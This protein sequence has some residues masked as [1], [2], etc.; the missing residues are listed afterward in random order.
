MAEVAAFAEVRLWGRT[1]GG[2]AE[3]DDGAVVF[4]YDPAFRR[5]GL[6]ISPTHLPLSTR[7]PVRF[8]ELTR[9]PGFRGLP[10]VLAD[11]LP[12]A[13]GTMV[14]RAYYTARGEVDKAFSPVQHLLYVGSRAIGALEFHPAEAL[15]L[16]PAESEALEVAAL[17][18]DARRIIAGDADVAIPEIY[19][20]G[21]SA[22]GMRPKAVVLHDPESRE[23]RSAFAP[24]GPEHVPAILKFDGVGPDPDD[25]G[26]G[27]PRPFNRIEAAYARMARDAGLDVV[28]VIVLES[29][30]G[31]A[32]LVIPRFDHPREGGL[33]Q[34]TFGGLLHLDYNDPGASSYEEYLRTILALGMPPA[35][36]IEGYRRMVF[37][38]LAVNQDDHV[39]NLSFHMDRDG[40][41]SL[42]PAY[43]L[44]FAKGAGWTATHQMRVADKRAGI[45]RA[46][47]LSVAATFGIRDPGG[48]VDRIADVVGDWPRYAAEQGVPDE[49]ARQVGAEL[50]AR[51]RATRV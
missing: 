36:V 1:V 21:S 47:L 18:A 16:R 48:I 39:K 43:D 17:V 5:S 15:P 38:V 49:A 28:D 31:H 3:L 8:A 11:A 34:H 20:M 29:A 6:E 32:H 40:V 19:R 22:G 7:G 44:T 10:G 50:E 24:A 42:T 27:E 41:W 33:H 35:A 12:D 25:A 14:I 37:N 4:E 2:V 51:S 46:D 26:L 30:E 23:I 9:K 13:F 45:T